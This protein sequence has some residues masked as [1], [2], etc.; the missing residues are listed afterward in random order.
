M[1]LIGKI[2]Y[3]LYSRMMT[4]KSWYFSKRVNNAGGGIVRKLHSSTS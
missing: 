1:K 3:S 2:A 4:Y